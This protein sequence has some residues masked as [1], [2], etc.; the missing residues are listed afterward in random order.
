MEKS[1]CAV[2]LEKRESSGATFPVMFLVVV[3]AKASVE[4]VRKALLGGLGSARTK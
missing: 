3:A 2:G 4:E 1:V